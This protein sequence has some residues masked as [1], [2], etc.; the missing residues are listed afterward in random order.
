MRVEELRKGNG[1]EKKLEDGEDRPSCGASSHRRA[2]DRGGPNAAANREPW[3]N[4]ERS[5]ATIAIRRTDPTTIAEV[6]KRVR[7]SLSPMRHPLNPPRNAAR[8]E[9]EGAIVAASTLQPRP[10]IVARPISASARA[11]PPD[12]ACAVAVM[13]PSGGP[14][15]EAGRHRAPSHSPGR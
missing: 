15:P 7:P 5:K 8:M 1:D 4:E 11:I 10:W 6:R 14:S 3:V 12:A 9:P 13:P 2:A